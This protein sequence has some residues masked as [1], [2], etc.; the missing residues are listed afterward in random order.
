MSCPTVEPL[1]W[2]ALAWS[3]SVQ[4]ANPQKARPSHNAPTGQPLQLAQTSPTTMVSLKL[5]SVRLCAEQ[6]ESSAKLL[7]RADYLDSRASNCLWPCCWPHFRSFPMAFF[8]LSYSLLFLILPPPPICQSPFFSITLS[9]LPLITVFF[10]LLSHLSC[11]LW[12]VTLLFFVVFWYSEVKACCTKPC[13]I[14]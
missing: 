1:Q 14:T 13:H 6:K 5:A 7:N 8:P 11:S 4:K 2:I 9:F 10:F 12:Q 3:T